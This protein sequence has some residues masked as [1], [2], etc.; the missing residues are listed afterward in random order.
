MGTI[1]IDGFCEVSP[2]TFFDVKGNPQA[3]GMDEKKD[4]KTKSI[5][6]DNLQR[7][8]YVRLW[9]GLK[10]T[11]S[12]GYGSGTTTGKFDLA[13]PNI[14]MPLHL[15]KYKVTDSEQ[16]TNRI[17]P[18]CQGS[19]GNFYKC[20]ECGIEVPYNGWTNAFLIDDEAIPISKQQ[21]DSIKELNT[22]KFIIFPVENKYGK[23]LAYQ[24]CYHS[25]LIRLLKDTPELN[26]IDEDGKAIPE[27]KLTSAK[28]YINATTPKKGEYEY[29]SLTNEKKWEYIEKVQN[30]EEKPILE[31]VKP[32]EELVSV[33]VDVF[34]MAT[35]E[36]KVA[37][38]VKVE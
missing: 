17:C 13:L 26:V 36:K 9:Y 27:D 30:G 2:T 18:Q 1:N 20:K 12:I 21:L 31:I 25:D 24:E 32:I 38:E 34:A 8:I 23:F 29:N 15:K 19:I 33:D 5:Q 14:P 4:K 7:D 16:G 37:V 3:I 6:K 35:Q 28:N 11:N 10:A 22:K